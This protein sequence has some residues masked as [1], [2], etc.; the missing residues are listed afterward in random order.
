[1]DARLKALRL[2]LKSLEQALPRFYS[3][4]TAG[5][6]CSKTLPAVSKKSDSA[7]IVSNAGRIPGLFPRQYRAPTLAASGKAWDS[8]WSRAETT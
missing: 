1:M 2:A 8:E 3:A 4:A 6:E 5:P 7:S